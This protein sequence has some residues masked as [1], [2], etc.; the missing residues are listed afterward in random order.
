VLFLCCDAASYVTGI[1]IPVDGGWS[2]GDAP[3]ALP[4]EAA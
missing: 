4:G 1:D 2:I 3:G